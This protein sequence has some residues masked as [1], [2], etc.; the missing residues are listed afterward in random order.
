[1][2]DARN[3]IWDYEEDEKEKILSIGDDFKQS[4]YSPVSDFYILSFVDS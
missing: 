4:N 3:G 1:M 2:D